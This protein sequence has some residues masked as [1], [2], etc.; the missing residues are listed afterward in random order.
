[1]A[2][3]KTEFRKADWKLTNKD[4][5]KFDKHRMTVLGG[6]FYQPGNQAT[7]I[8]GQKLSALNRIGLQEKIERHYKLN[9]NDEN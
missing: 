9:R 4:K 7:C 1:M 8:C 6:D 3:L 2:L 5:P